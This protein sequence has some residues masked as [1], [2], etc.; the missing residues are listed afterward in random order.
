MTNKLPEE[1][2]KVHEKTLKLLDGTNEQLMNVQEMLRKSV[3][4]LS[5]VARRDDVRLDHVLDNIKSSVKNKL[6]MLRMRRS[7]LRAIVKTLPKMSL[8]KS[9]HLL[10]SLVSHL[11]INLK[12]TRMLMCQ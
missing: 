5:I 6:I 2:I 11:I 10:I 8:L 4:R 7:I 9:D 12:L 1:V 3:V